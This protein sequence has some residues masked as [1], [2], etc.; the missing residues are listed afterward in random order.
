MKTKYTIFLT[1]F[2][3][4][5]SY[6]L[7]LRRPTEPM[8]NIGMCENITSGRLKAV[9]YAMFFKN[10]TY[11]KLAADFTPYCYDNVF[12]LLDVD[13]RTCNNLEDTSAKLSCYTNLAINQKNASVCE[14]LQDTS[15]I[16]ICY[17][18]L[19][20]HLDVFDDINLCKKI[21]HESTKF[22]CMAMVS[23]NINFCFNITQEVFERG[24]CVAMFTRNVSDCFM[25]TNGGALA[26]IT[27]SSCIRQVAISTRNV[28]MCEM[29]G[30]AEDRWRCKMSMIN[31]IHV[32]DEIDDPWKDICK[33]EYIKNNI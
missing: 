26:R 22:T 12:S 20:D 13:E 28:S 24:F 6:A 29:I 1:F 10:Y 21:P 27:F 8:P 7:W 15:L 31:D 23:K 5:I 16:N 30:R 19:S 14:F 2:I 25:P 33:L 17:G 32:C 9:C 3:L 11:C 4:A 18:R